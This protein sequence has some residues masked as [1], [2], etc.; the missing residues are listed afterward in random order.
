MFD[1]IR[2]CLWIGCSDYP[3]VGDGAISPSPNIIFHDNIANLVT[4]TDFNCLSAMQFAVEVY[5]VSIIV[6]CG[7]YGCRGVTTA[8]ADR[9]FDVLSNWLRPVVRLADKYKFLIERIAEA[10]DRLDA[11]CELNV[12]DQVAAA[13]STTVVQKTWASGQNLSVHGLI[14][15]RRTVLLA[16]F[17]VCISGNDE[18]STEHAAAI[19]AFVRRWGL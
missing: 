4:A 3:G 16:D 7:H 12:I 1:D 2:D 10:S 14:Y 8:I 15:D 5:R 9:R 19:A 18:L 6:V 11:L 13:C 17:H